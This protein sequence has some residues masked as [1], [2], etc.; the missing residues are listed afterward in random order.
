MLNKDN[1]VPWSSCLLRYD[2]RRPNGKLIY[3]SIMNGLYE[4]GYDVQQDEGFDIELREKAQLFITGKGQ[5]AQLG[6]NMGQDRHMQMVGGNG[7]NQFRQYTGRMLG[8]R[9]AAR[10]EG[11]AIGNNVNQIRCYIC[12]GLGHHCWNCNSSDQGE[13]MLPYLQT[14]LLI[15]QKEEAGIQL[16]VEEFD[17]MV[18]AADLDEIE[19]VNANCILMAN[20]QQ[21]VI[22]YTK[23]LKPIPEPHKVQHND[24]NVISEVSSVEQDGG[25]VDQHPVT[26][27]ETR[28]YFE[29]LYNN[30]AIEVEK[31]SEQKDTTKIVSHMLSQN[32]STSNSVPI[33]QESKV[34]KNDNVIASG[35]FRINQIKL[36]REEKYVPKK[37]I[38]SVR[39]NPIIVSQPHVI[40][41][42]D[43]N[44]DSNGFSSIGIDNTAKTRRPQP[45]SNTKNDR[46]PSA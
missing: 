27:E 39:T 12:R 13:W 1:Y 20:L 15:A 11:N 16:Q 9:I 19:E 42:K 29:S 22:R 35:M 33:L 43:V 3:N 4:S 17:L 36:S 38:A 21:A 34:V 14:Q 40:T 44:S 8:I 46:V 6:M 28:A 26:V 2:K 10:A 30:L 7:G 37:A 25:T 45:K 23:L 31:V 32:K 5:I 18:A 41:K 24:S